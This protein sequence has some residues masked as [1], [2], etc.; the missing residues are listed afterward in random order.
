[1]GDPQSASLE[2]FVTHL[3]GEAAVSGV[4][5]LSVERWGRAVVVV[6]EGSPLSGALLAPLVSGAIEAASGRGVECALL[7]RDEHFA[8]VLVGGERGVG[9]VREWIAGGLP[10]GEALT[11]MQGG[12]S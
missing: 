1:M 5:A 3:A 4:G 7:S 2:T 12:A 9:R 11:R 6:M 8:R 10:W